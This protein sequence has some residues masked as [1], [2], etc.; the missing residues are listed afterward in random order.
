ME[1]LIEL[2]QKSSTVIDLVSLAFAIFTIIVMWM[3]FSKAGQGGWKIFI[4]IYNEYIRFKIANSTGK[5]WATFFMTLAALPIGGYAAFNF[6]TVLYTNGASGNSNTTILLVCAGVAALMLLICGII[7]ITVN[8]SM[9]KA[10]D[11][12]GVFGLGLWLLPVIFYAVIAFSSDIQY[13]SRKMHPAYS[14]D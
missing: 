7:R 2:Y 5:Y 9:A 11:L 14:E 13:A 8:F 12:P 3:V 10:F 6:F 4:P 1:E